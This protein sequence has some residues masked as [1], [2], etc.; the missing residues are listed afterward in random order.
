MTDG[1]DPDCIGDSGGPLPKKS[2]E[3]GHCEDGID[4]DLDGKTDDADKDCQ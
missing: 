1:D 4:N 2:P 3:K